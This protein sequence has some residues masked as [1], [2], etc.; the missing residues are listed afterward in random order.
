MPTLSFFL[1]FR[2]SLYQVHPSRSLRPLSDAAD[3]ELDANKGGRYPRRMQLYG[4]G[5]SSSNCDRSGMFLRSHSSPDRG[6]ATQE[7]RVYLIR[8][9]NST[10]VSRKVLERSGRISEVQEAPGILDGYHLRYIN[11][12]SISRDKVP[13]MSILTPRI[14]W[15]AITSSAIVGPSLCFYTY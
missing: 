11:L 13:D 6:L 1:R 12:Y 8:S 3:V 2:R 5:K 15:L 4:C 14:G 9:E 10:E 7:V